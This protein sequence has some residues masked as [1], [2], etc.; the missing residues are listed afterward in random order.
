MESQRA[1]REAFSDRTISQ[2]YRWKTRW[3][4]PPPAIDWEKREKKEKKRKV[5]LGGLQSRSRG[6][7]IKPSLASISIE[8]FNRL[9]MKLHNFPLSHT[10]GN[11]QLFVHGPWTTPHRGLLR[12]HETK[13]LFTYE[14]KRLEGRNANEGWESETFPRLS[15]KRNPTWG[16][17]H[18][19]L[20]TPLHSNSEVLFA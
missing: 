7:T 17:F 8:P 4:R 5:E 3:F 10:T 2:K 12:Q 20:T 1:D 13:A 16:E 15:V 19:T 6:I 9:L 11:L 14:T 18:E